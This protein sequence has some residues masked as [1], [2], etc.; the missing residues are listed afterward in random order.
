MFDLI[1][2]GDST[3]DTIVI[4]DEA[5]VTCDLKKEHCMLCLSYADKIP[6]QCCRW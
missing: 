2:I 5:K 6:G 3:I 4:I 1:T